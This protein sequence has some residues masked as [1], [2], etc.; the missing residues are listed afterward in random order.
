MRVRIPCQREVVWKLKWKHGFHRIIPQLS[1][2]LISTPQR[3]SL[4]VGR[5][6]WMQRFLVSVTCQGFP[7][8]F[9]RSGNVGSISM[10]VP[11]FKI[12]L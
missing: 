8:I 7:P 6:N 9:F 2:T 4:H 12:F 11:S 10:S 5:R 3:I 1:P